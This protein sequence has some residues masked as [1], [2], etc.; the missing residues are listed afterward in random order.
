MAEQDWTQNFEGVPL[1]HRSKAVPNAPKTENM[2][3]GSIKD[4][5][6]ARITYL[7]GQI[8]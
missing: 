1:M 5:A 4:L 7:G 2:G 6:G 8:G 3:D